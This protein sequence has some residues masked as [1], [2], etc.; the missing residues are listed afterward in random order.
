MRAE[1]R[2]HLLAG[3]VEF[4]KRRRISS[5]HINFPEPPEA[6]TLTEAG[7]LLR[8]GQQFHWTNGG[9]RDFDDFLAALNSRKRKAVKKERREALA[10]GLAIDVLSGSD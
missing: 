1:A 4:T 2:D 10:R 6:E 3:M 7:F 8:L 9:Y 5:L